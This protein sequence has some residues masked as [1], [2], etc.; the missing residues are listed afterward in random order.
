MVIIIKIMIIIQNDDT[1]T[2]TRNQAYP[3]Y[4]LPHHVSSIS[5]VFKIT[6][7]LH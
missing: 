6:E 5:E 3:E 1:R 7:K 2:Q 4:E